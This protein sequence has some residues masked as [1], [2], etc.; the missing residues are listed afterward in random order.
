MEIIINFYARARSIDYTP[1]CGWSGLF[2]YFV[3]YF[4][5]TVASE[6]LG[7]LVGIKLSHGDRS[8]VGLRHYA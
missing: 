7:P 3:L 4:L 1:S 2:S 5:P 8:D 6:I